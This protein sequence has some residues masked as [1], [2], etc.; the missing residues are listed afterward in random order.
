[1][2]QPNIIFITCDHLRADF[3]GCAGNAVIQTPHID[4]L[5]ARG[6]RFTQSYSSTPVCIPARQIILTGLTGHNLGLTYYQEGFKIPVRETLPRL[7]TEAGYQTR[8]VGK[9]HIYPERDHHGFESMLICEEGRRLGVTQNEDRGYGDYEEW[10]AEQGYPGE[11]WTCGIANN[12]ITMRPWH[13]PD[14]LHPTEWI[15]REACKA[16]KRRDWTRPQFLWVSFTSPHPPFMPLL[17]DLYI[18]EKETMPEPLFGDWEKEYQPLMHQRIIAEWSSESQTLQRI[19]QAYR[20]YFALMS[21]VDRWINII[22]GTVR[23]AGL[24]DNT[25]FVFTSDHGDCMGD[26]GL[27]A[28]RN[29][30]KGA[31]NVPLI[32]T[33]PPRGDL[34]QLI[35][36]G[37]VP[38]QSNNAVVGLQDIMPTILDI[39]GAGIP[40]KIDGSSLLPLIKGS[41]EKVREMFLGEHG[42][43]G[44][45]LFMLTDGSWKYIWEENTGS[46][47]L[48]QIADD[49]DELRN[50]V[51]VQPQ[52]LSNW[53][54]KLI[55]LLSERKSDPAV[56]E[57]QLI[58]KEPGRKMTELE[59]A[60]IINDFN[61]RGLH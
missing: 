20:G 4:F 6:T 50:L 52:M 48:F 45:R 1:M 40:E 26:H 33:P 9:M 12:S 49:P 43:V 15:G 13:L 53:R 10:L 39:A 3:L 11:A 31:C 7:M 27:W 46:E 38:G 54:K 30:M 36:A 23:E 8:A 61:V 21:Q 28:K 2:P 34:D 37:W 25:W 42:K 24:L 14:H 58:P 35:G 59:K 16:I 19:N 17:R 55:Q 41:R 56:L 5:A 32:I 22:I 18:Y 47:L 44:E 51:S 57:G 29:F 60:R